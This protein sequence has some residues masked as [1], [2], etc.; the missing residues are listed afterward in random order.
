[1]FSPKQGVFLSAET[2]PNSLEWSGADSLLILRDLDQSGMVMNVSTGKP[3][4]SQNGMA[5]AHPNI[6]I[7]DNDA[8][9]VSVT[10]NLPPT[11]PANTIVVSVKILHSWRGDLVVDL[12]SPDGKTARLWNAVGGSADN[13]IETWSSASHNALA[14]LTGVSGA[15]TWTLKV[16]DTGRRDIGTLEYVRISCS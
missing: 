6:Q 8:K 11:T 15:G 1:M 2:I 14:G 3:P 10:L 7:P 13:L 4:V 5:E 9:G 12:T 16:A